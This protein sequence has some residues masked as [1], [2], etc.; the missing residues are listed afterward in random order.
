MDHT[1]LAMSD[2]TA[3]GM[4]LVGLMMGAF[5]LVMIVMLIAEARRGGKR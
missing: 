2:R 3:D 5:A 4:W 1:T